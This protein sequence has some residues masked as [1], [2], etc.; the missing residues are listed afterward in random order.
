MFLGRIRTGEHSKNMTS[1]HL[2][3]TLT[4]YT[5]TS[6]FPTIHL[7]VII[8]STRLATALAV[9]IAAPVIMVRRLIDCL[10]LH[11]KKVLR[12]NNFGS[13]RGCG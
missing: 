12:H 8:L 10:L 2:T 6:Y 13:T 3:K 5:P 1:K 9:R 11:S 7:N 4:Y